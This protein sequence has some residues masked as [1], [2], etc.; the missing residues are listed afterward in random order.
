VLN[1][2][3]KWRILLLDFQLCFGP[4]GLASKTIRSLMAARFCENW[5]RSAPPCR[6]EA[7]ATLLSGL[8]YH[9][10]RKTHCKRTF[11][12]RGRACGIAA[13]PIASCWC[14]SDFSLSVC[15]LAVLGLNLHLKVQLVD[16]GVYVQ[17]VA[18]FDV[19]S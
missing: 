17:R 1:A 9:E 10:A 19:A 16:G 4:R 15:W 2:T 7:D 5:A 6:L 8:P 12:V 11:R 14:W 18:C 3:T 13:A